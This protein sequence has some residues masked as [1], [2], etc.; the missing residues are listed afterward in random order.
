MKID[1]EH[2]LRADEDAPE[3]PTIAEWLKVHGYTAVSNGKI[4]HNLD[5]KDGWSEKPWRP[6]RIFRDYQNPE[7]M[8]I[9]ALGVMVLPRS[10]EVNPLFTRMI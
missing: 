1:L 5:S 10:V 6:D 9:V 2:S 4:L 8:R 7:N 3:A